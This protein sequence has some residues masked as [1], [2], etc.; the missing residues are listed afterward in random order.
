MDVGRSL[1]ETKS[2]LQ[3]ASNYI[4]H[5]KFGFG[6]IVFMDKTL[7]Q[8]KLQLL[9]AHNIPTFP[10]FTLLEVSLLEYHCR[11]YMT[12]ARVLGFSSVWEKLFGDGKVTTALLARITHHCDILETDNDSY[13][14]KQRKKELKTE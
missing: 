3:I 7:L 2:T 13:R 1:E 4:D 10:S 11:V 9:A 5:R 12:H 6:T 14:F 8:E